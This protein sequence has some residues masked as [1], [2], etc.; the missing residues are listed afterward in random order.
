MGANVGAR[1]DRPPDELTELIR[2][3]HHPHVIVL[4]ETK[5]T[6]DTSDAATA[7][8]A[9]APDAYKALGYAAYHHGPTPA[10]RAT[11]AESRHQDT[12]P[13]VNASFEERE[14]HRRA[15]Q[16]STARTRFGG[17]SLLVREDLVCECL[18]RD[19]DGYQIAAE[20]TTRA[21]NAPRVRILAVYGQP[22]TDGDAQWKRIHDRLKRDG[23]RAPHVVIGDFNAVVDPVMDRRTIDATRLVPLAPTSLT[24]SKHFASIVLKTATHVDAWRH[25]NGAKALAFSWRV[26]DTVHKV[27]RES[28]IDGALV[29]DDIADDIVDC[30]YGGERDRLRDH[31]PIT[32][33]LRTLRVPR[34]TK[35]D[36]HDPKNGDDDG[37]NTHHASAST[38]TQ[39]RIRS[40]PLRGDEEERKQ[41]LSCVESALKNVRNDCESDSVDDR[42]GAV[43]NAITHALQE[44]KLIEKTDGKQ[45]TPFDPHAHRRA[46]A[47]WRSL[48][49]QSKRLRKAHAATLA[50]VLT[51]TTSHAKYTLPHSVHKVALNEPEWK[52]TSVASPPPNDDRAAIAQWTQEVAVLCQQIGNKFAQLCRKL[53]HQHFAGFVDKVLRTHDTDVRRWWRIYANPE[54]R[55][56][57]SQK[58]TLTG[59]RID[60]EIHTDADSVKQTV[61]DFYQRLTARQ[62]CDAAEVTDRNWPEWLAHYGARKPQIYS[63]AYDTNAAALT[64]PITDGELARHLSAMKTDKASGP[65]NMPPEV[66]KYLARDTSAFA[67]LKTLFNG[68]LTSGT[69]PAAWRDASI[70]MI[71]KAGDEHD[72][73]NYRPITLTNVSYRLFMS[74]IAARLGAHLERFGVITNAQS[75]F[76]ARRGCHDAIAKS[77]AVHTHA[78]ETNTPLS[79]MYI[80]L[81]KA[82]DSVPHEALLATL[83]ALCLPE[84]FVRLIA[85]VYTDNR[86]RVITTHGLTEWIRVG[87]GL[88]QGCPASCVFF[89]VFIDPILASLEDTTVRSPHIPVLRGYAMARDN[90]QV[91]LRATGFADD[92]KLFATSMSN[93][94]KIADRYAEFCVWNGVRI[95]LEDP[96]AAVKQKTVF[97]TSDPLATT[98]P[99]TISVYDPTSSTHSTMR[100]V[101]RIG[102]DETY[103]YLGVHLAHSLDWT[104][105]LN[106]L[107]QKANRFCAYASRRMFSL[108]HAVQAINAILIPRITYTLPALPAATTPAVAKT[109]T[110]IDKRIKRVVALKTQMRTGVHPLHLP[111]A[112]LGVGLVHLPSLAAGIQ[113]DAAMRMQHC[114]DMC[115]R[116]ASRIVFPDGG[117]SRVP[118]TVKSKLGLSVVDRDETRESMEFVWDELFERVD[119]RVAAAFAPAERDA[120]KRLCR[121]KVRKDL[122]RANTD[123]LVSQRELASSR[124]LG[125]ELTDA[126]YARLCDAFAYEAVVNG[127][128]VHRVHP[129]LLRELITPTPL[130]NDIPVAASAPTTVRMWTDG[131]ATPATADAPAKVALGVYAPGLPRIGRYSRALRSETHTNNTAELLAIVECLQLAAQHAPLAELV[132]YTDSQSMMQLALDDVQQVFDPRKP[133]LPIRARPWEPNDS[134]IARLALRE[135]LEHRQQRLASVGI[136]P[137]RPV[138]DDG[139]L[140]AAKLQIMHVFSHLVDD[141]VDKTS[142][143]YTRK[144]AEMKRRYGPA[145]TYY[146]LNNRIAD[147][148]ANSERDRRGA[149]PPLHPMVSRLN[150]DFVVVRRERV[151]DKN[152]TTRVVVDT[153]R[154]IHRD[155]TRRVVDDYR[156]GAEKRQQA[157]AL[158]D[159]RVPITMLPEWQ[160]N[161]SEI[162]HV[163][164]GKLV[165]R[166]TSLY[167]R[168]H[169]LNFALKLWHDALPHC[170]QLAL[171]LINEERRQREEEAR[172]DAASHYA[173]VLGP[174]YSFGDKCVWAECSARESKW[175]PLEGHECAHRYPSMQQR[176]AKVRA[177]VADALPAESRH[178]AFEIPTWWHA[179]AADTHTPP[180]RD[181]ALRR[182]ADFPK[183]WGSRGVVPSALGEFLRSQRLDTPAVMDVIE[184][185]MT[186]IV[187]TAHSMW[188]ERCSQFQRLWSQ[189]RKDNPDVRQP[190][191]ARRSPPAAESRPTQPDSDTDDNDDDNARPRQP[192]FPLFSSRTVLSAPPAAD[193][194]TQVANTRRRSPPRPRLRPSQTARPALNLAGK[195][196]HRGGISI[197]DESDDD[198]D[199]NHDDEVDRDEKRR[200]K[201]MSAMRATRKEPLPPLSQLSFSPSLRRSGQSSRRAQAPTPQPTQRVSSLTPSR[202][203]VP[204]SASPTAPTTTPSTSRPTT[205]MLFNQTSFTTTPTMTPTLSADPITTTPRPKSLDRT[206]ARRK[207]A[208]NDPADTLTHTADSDTDTDESDTDREER[209]RSKSD[210]RPQR[211]RL[212]QTPP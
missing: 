21:R 33:K 120:L 29:R 123:T 117:K 54:K 78:K 69:I 206:Y 205:S 52:P 25:V 196:L 166:W 76:R 148:L 180:T 94:K 50:C 6:H 49:L 53:D 171:E 103:K 45:R 164:M 67:H 34:S 132:I 185:V 74:I 158:A 154:E 194:W 60:G 26:H 210:Q 150:G 37:D 18:E 40:A 182:I 16:A 177:V 101:P 102:L 122:M 110:T 70:W 146:A 131:S 209:R 172:G 212:R 142:E 11:R 162:D 57:L 157:K 61:F 149:T 201:I 81:A 39:E 125:N 168:A 115:T 137:K 7:R 91:E 108:A 207:R 211:A 124:K 32:L 1:C 197:P 19:D 59:V 55:L 188:T 128:T 95:S 65:D 139:A 13:A 179:H 87:R 135:Q 73:A 178:L 62:P 134:L 155:L 35:F 153:R 165:T 92:L 86:V 199:D 22:G 129:H 126:T 195:S 104:R 184:Q 175:H 140:S 12:M 145:W 84:P 167:E 96:A 138:G 160:L 191:I 83:K 23:A 30:Q 51:D 77:I 47:E 28:R 190:V 72:P 121:L 90:L 97:S 75:G 88:R 144:C 17:V 189:H 79:V 107:I 63:E 64:D 193:H 41:F 8:A 98:T 5:H 89:N 42:L 151:A 93:L 105:Q 15:I 111:H 200:A 43:H 56:A 38:T 118:T 109:L 48:R 203:S 208:A 58:K 143:E 3:H 36:N 186:I 127:N 68:I 176:Y 10:Q 187:S 170:R 100:E 113:T 112:D 71:F 20:I 66:Y 114:G 141:N 161:N 133:L 106:E 9:Y 136:S 163:A 31:V 44:R 173:H 85:D 147:E 156:K 99:L 46:D 119:L 198:D 116:I 204:A 80:D 169:T 159:Q 130:P 4:C 2:R 27:I 174:K 192:I 183:R 181:V 152:T 24:T 202:R 82:Y 14:A